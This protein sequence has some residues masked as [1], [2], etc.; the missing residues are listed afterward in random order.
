MRSILFAEDW[1]NP[2]KDLKLYLEELGSSFD[3][4]YD[5]TNDQMVKKFKIKVV[6]TS[7][8]LDE[9]N[10]EVKRLIGFNKNKFYDFWSTK[11]N[12]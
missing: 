7:I 8:I 1:C 11:I 6:P 9:N 3:E 2:S 10:K 12:D 4:I 5:L